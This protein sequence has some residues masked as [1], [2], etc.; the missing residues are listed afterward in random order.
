MAKTGPKPSCLCGTCPKCRARE[1]SHRER[2]G[3]PRLPNQNHVK[4][5]VARERAVTAAQLRID[6]LSWREIASRLGY[7]RAG[8]AKNAVTRKG[9]IP[10]DLV[11]ALK[12]VYDLRPVK[13]RCLKC[14]TCVSREKEAARRRGDR[15]SYHAW[16]RLG[17]Q[18]RRVHLRS[19]TDLTVADDLAL[20]KSAKRCPLCRHKLTDDPHLPRSKEL[21]HIVPV[22]MGGTHT[23]GNIRIICRACNVARPYDGSDLVGVQTSLGSAARAG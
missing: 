17:A 15:D 11:E 12:A 23:W 18:L 16:A 4:A 21:D 9:F 6:G 19:G 7:A 14:S 1:R 22:N 8:C 13:C 2:H 20:R 5:R 3:L 10:D